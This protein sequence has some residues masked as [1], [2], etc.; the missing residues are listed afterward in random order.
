MTPFEFG[1]KLSVYNDVLNLTCFNLEIPGPD[2]RV[3]LNVASREYRLDIENVNFIYSRNVVQ[4]L[5][6]NWLVLL[7]HRA[8]S[9][10][11]S[12]RHPHESQR[13]RA[14]RQLC[15]LDRS[16]ARVAA[17]ARACLERRMRRC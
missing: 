7:N 16:I 11:W 17:K 15:E 3:D 6:T 4:S 10:F 2:A 14:A 1:K 5:Q 9:L 12:E 8:W 13:V